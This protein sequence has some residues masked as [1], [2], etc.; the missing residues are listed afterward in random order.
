[1]AKNMVV[2]CLHGV[3]CQLWNQNIYDFILSL[4]EM[5]CHMLDTAKMNNF[6]NAV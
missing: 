3:L 2:I 6:V 1:M 5:T 4:Q